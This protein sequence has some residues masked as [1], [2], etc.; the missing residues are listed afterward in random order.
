MDPRQEKLEE[1]FAELE[2]GIDGHLEDMF[3]DRLSLHP[4]R[5]PRGK[6]SNPIYDGLFS[7]TIVFSMGYGTQY[8]RGYIVNVGV[9]TLDMIDPELKD[10]IMNEAFHYTSEHYMDYLPDRK[11]QVVRD[12]GL[13][14]LIGDFSLN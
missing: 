11:I 4:S 6:G 13:I 8:G 3:G 9:S 12:M 7:A 1:Q 14:K 2:K 10:Q 5:M